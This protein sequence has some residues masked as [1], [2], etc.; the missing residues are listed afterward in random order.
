MISN[1]TKKYE[2]QKNFKIKK[3]R[4]TKLKRKNEVEFGNF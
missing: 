4:E 1:H 3:Y 2:R